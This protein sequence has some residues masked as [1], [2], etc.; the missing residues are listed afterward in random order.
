MSDRLKIGFGF[1]LICLIWGSTWLVIRIGLNSLTP[2]ISAGIRF[3]LASLIIFAVIKIKKIKLQT[4]PLSLK[5]YVFLG[6][7]AFTFPYG[8]VYWAEQYIPSGLTSILFAIMPFSII[9][10]THLMIKNNVITP[11]QIIGVVIGFVGVVI[12]FSDS[13]RIEFS[14]YFFGMLA[15]LFSALIQAFV[16]VVIKKY[17]K[18]LHPLSMN[19]LPLLMGGLIMIPAGLIFEDKSN[20]K[21]DFIAISSIIYLALF[22]TVVTFTIYY[23]L[24][25]KMNIVILSLNAF[26]TPVV[27]VI[28][29]WIVLNEK[30][31]LQVLI[32][33][34]LVFIGILF[35]NLRQLLIYFESKRKII[36][37]DKHN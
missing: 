17:G 24:I 26:I 13:L 20:W 29:G 19:F 6:F 7:F 32:G 27:A 4:D 37:D 25:K 3:L 15:A 1:A 18:D 9:L 8:L 16:A 23:W 35:A 36:Y 14:L 11:N 28:L 5:L 21:F 34:L 31:S 2:I 12:I 33:S 10:F 30:L 22:G